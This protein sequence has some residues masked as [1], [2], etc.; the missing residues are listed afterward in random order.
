MA[1]LSSLLIS[2][3]CTLLT[4]TSTPEISL[5]LFIG[6]YLSLSLVCYTFFSPFAIFFLNIFV[7]HVHVKELATE[8]HNRQYTLLAIVV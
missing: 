8:M 4:Q 5:V 2:S 6:S 3:H 1:S 7:N